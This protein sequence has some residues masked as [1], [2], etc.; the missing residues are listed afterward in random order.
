[1]RNRIFS[2]DSAKAVK[3]QKVGFLNAIHY[4]APASLSGKNLCANASP[5]CI[6]LCLGWFSGQ[7]GMV[8]LANPTNSVRKSRIEKAQRFMHGR[9]EYM[10]DVVKSISDVKRKAR[11]LGFKVCIRMNG[12]SDIPWEHVKFNNFTVTIFDLFPHTQFVD[13]TKSKARALKWARGQ[14]PANYDLTFSRSET[15]E[16]DCLEVL[17]AGGKVAVVFETLPETWHGYQVIN[18]DETDLRHLDPRGV[19]I[20]LLPKG[21]AAKKDQSGFVVR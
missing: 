19:V 2:T 21:S 12:S 17:A 16:A 10:A 8:S 4:L 14:M 20:G 1:M 3:A 5:G 18:G 13:Y 6:A 9:D 11:K 7:A 15:N